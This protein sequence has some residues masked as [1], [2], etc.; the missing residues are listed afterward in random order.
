MQLFHS[1]FTIQVSSFILLDQIT[2]ALLASRDFFFGP[3]KV[4]LVKNHGLPFGLNSSSATSMIVTAIILSALIYYY[5][6]NRNKFSSRDRIG[7]AFILGGAISNIIDRIVF[8]YVRDYLDLSLTFVFNLA[9]VFIVIGIII[10]ILGTKAK[11]EFS[12]TA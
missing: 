3:I 9:D 12:K 10:L 8:G 2:K 5:F 7:Y 11:G 6:L 1:R 4:E